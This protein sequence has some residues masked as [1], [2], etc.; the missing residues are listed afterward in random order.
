MAEGLLRAAY[1]DRYDVY[2]AGIK[3]T[4]VDPRAIKVMI[5][6]GFLKKICVLMST[7]RSRQNLKQ[8]LS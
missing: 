5:H 4:S 2:S 3:A 1:G 8:A 6:K 7:R